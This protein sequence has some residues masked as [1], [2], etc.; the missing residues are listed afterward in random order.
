MPAR[1]AW[2][3]LSLLCFAS[4]VAPASDPPV[5]T[6]ATT[7]WQKGQEALRDDAPDKAIAWFEESLRLDPG[8]ACNHLSLA[9]SFVALG[10]DEQAADS[11]ARYLA[12]QPDHHVVRAHYAELLLRLSRPAA[13]RGQFERFIVDAQK[14]EKL[15]RQHLIHC[16]SRLMEI[17]EAAEDAY[18]EHLHRGIGLYLLAVQRS[19]LPEIDGVLPTE[20]LLCRAA[21]ELALAWKERPDEARPCWYLHVVWSQ[22]AQAKPAARW[23]RAAEDSAPFGD[24]TPSEQA[25]LQLACR[26][27]AAHR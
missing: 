8:L 12:A 7:L 26:R 14:D 13:A 17:A 18:A 21:G 11:L 9:A 2:V 6:P 16:H 25:S 5:P 4:V 1:H 10:R 27:T 15:A 22:L 23:L 3:S 24:L 20:G 19:Q